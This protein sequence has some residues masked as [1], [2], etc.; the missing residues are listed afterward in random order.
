MV[1]QPRRA[2]NAFGIGPGERQRKE[3]STGRTQRKRMWMDE[4]LEWAVGGGR[5]AAAVALTR[6]LLH[7]TFLH[8]TSTYRACPPPFFDLLQ[9]SH[10]WSL[11]IHLLHTNNK[12]APTPSTCASLPSLPS[13]PPAPPLR[14]THHHHR[15]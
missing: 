5:F 1:Y 11:S 14:R 4:Q 7:I 13:W 8:N 10:R 6:A 12:Q 2:T 3:F 9:I 15:C